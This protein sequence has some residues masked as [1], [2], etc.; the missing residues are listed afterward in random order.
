MAAGD[1]EK[2][3]EAQSRLMPLRLCF[4]L[5]TVPDPVKEAAR[6]IGLPMGLNAAPIGPMSDETIAQL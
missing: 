6:A 3:W 1:L 4:A 5:G 2:A